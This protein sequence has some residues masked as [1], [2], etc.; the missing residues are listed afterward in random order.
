MKNTKQAKLQLSRLLGC[1]QRPNLSV[2]KTEVDIFCISKVIENIVT[3]IIAENSNLQKLH[4][5]PN[6]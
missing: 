1:N 3:G 6:I 2:C 4:G 5:Q